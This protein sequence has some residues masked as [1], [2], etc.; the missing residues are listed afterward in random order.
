VL[1][2]VLGKL[3]KAGLA[4]YWTKCMNNAWGSARTGTGCGASK[5]EERCLADAEQIAWSKTE[6][7]A[8]AECFATG[9]SSRKVP[10]AVLWGSIRTGAGLVTW[11]SAGTGTGDVLGLVLGNLVEAGWMQVFCKVLTSNL[12][13]LVFNV[14]E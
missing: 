8:E 9:Q 7:C 3:L 13:I 10:G 6:L 14:P 1:G 11:Q 5:C 12:K 2:L 4:R